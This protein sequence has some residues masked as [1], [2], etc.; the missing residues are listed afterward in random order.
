MGFLDKM[1]QAS[2]DALGKAQEKISTSLDDAK[3]ERQS[4]Q[5]AKEQEKS[6]QKELARVFKPTKSLG[7]LSVDTVNGLF[8]V[9]HATA[10]MP[11]RSGALAKTGKAV[12]AMYTLGASIAIEHA[13][14]PDDKIFRFEELRGYEL[15]E[16][17]SEVTSGGLGRAAVGAA[18]FGSTGALV[19]AMT[20]KKKSK[21]VVETLVLKIDLY[22][23]DFPCVM[24]P[25]IN[26]SVKVT[27]N[28]YKKAYG[29]AQESI[30]CLDLIIEIM[31]RQRESQ[32]ARQQPDQHDA[33]EQIKKYKELL[34]LGAITQEEFDSK[35]QDLLGL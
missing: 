17:D 5:L 12:A 1:K 15:L 21:K 6:E 35:K 10:A 33:V 4:K 24:V 7:D 27:D 30:S 3:D 32:P 22:D 28:E 34:D 14:K 19:G 9:R 13:M 26:K 31:Q 18:A 8:K 20:G 23:L 2:G 29:A 16:D 25:Y 11:K